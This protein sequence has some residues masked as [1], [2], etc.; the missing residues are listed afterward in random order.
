MKIYNDPLR[1]RIKVLRD[2]VEVIL[3]VKVRSWVHLL[4]RVFVTVDPSTSL[5][6]T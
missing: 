4:Q 3:H 5:H 1:S 2:T 6:D